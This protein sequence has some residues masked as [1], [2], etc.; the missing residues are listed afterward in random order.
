MEMGCV[1]HALSD[2]GKVSPLMRYRP[3]NR[4]ILAIVLDSGGGVIIL[5]IPPLTTIAMPALSMQLTE[6]RVNTILGAYKTLLSRT[7]VHLDPFGNSI[8]I[9]PLPMALTGRLSTV[10]ISL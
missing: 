4:G 10:W 2:L 7:F 1:A 6:M 8:I 9:S 3:C 5:H